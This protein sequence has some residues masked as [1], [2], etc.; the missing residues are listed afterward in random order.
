M[1]QTRAPGQKAAGQGPSRLQLPRSIKLTGRGA[2]ASLFAASFLGLLIAAW[3][4]WSTFA[5]V[6]FVM[7]CGVVTCYTRV[8]GLRALVVCPPLAFFAGSVLAQ[9]LT[10]PDTFSAATGILVT[11][12]SSALWLFTGTAL[13]VVIALGRGYRPE[14][15]AM[16]LLSKLH[17]ALWDLWS[18]R[19]DR[20]GR[21]R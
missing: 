20:W 13:V 3:T 9:V 7:T 17:G 21:R 4:G 19:G 1:T 6:M 18:A 12:G 8:S 11:L 14:V 10:A 5:D 16:A 2:V 15:R